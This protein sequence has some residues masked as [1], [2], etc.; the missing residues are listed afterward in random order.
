MDIQIYTGSG[1]GY[2]SKAKELMERAG[3]EYTEIRIG[4]GITRE[5]FKEKFD[6]TSYP[7]IMIDGNHIGGLVETVRYMVEQKLITKGSV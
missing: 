2:C 1:C 6:K 4:K 3:F 5:E 7:Q